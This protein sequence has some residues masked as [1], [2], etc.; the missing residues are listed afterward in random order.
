M[1]PGPR[2]SCAWRAASANWPV[3]HGRFAH[4]SVKRCANTERDTATSRA[5]SSTVQLRC[6][7]ACSKR[8]LC[9]RERRSTQRASLPDWRAHVACTRGGSRRS[10]AVEVVSQPRTSARGHSERR[11]DI[12]LSR[13]ARRVG[14]NA[15]AAACDNSV[16]C[17]KAWPAPSHVREKW[18]GPKRDVKSIRSS[19]SHPNEGGIVKGSFCSIPGGRRAIPIWVGLEP[20]TFDVTDTP[21]WKEH[22]NWREGSAG[23]RRVTLNSDG[24]T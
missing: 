15:A 1:L 2:A 14:M 4:N 8:N 16:Q 20:T 3:S 10:R 5:S 13:I 7:S 21:W 12:G 18:F 17:A 23:T 9:P 24:Y 19:R 6:G 11:T 22:G